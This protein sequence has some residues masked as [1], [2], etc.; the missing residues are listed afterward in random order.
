MN[1]KTEKEALD[2]IYDVAKNVLNLDI[3][4]AKKFLHK[5]A[6]QWLSSSYPKMLFNIS[7]FE[8]EKE[9][10]AFSVENKFVVFVPI[11][12]KSLTKYF[13]FLC[14]DTNIPQELFF[15]LIILKI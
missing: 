4:V 2:I 1:V 8:S 10:K 5:D 12:L 15:I 11:E 6:Y 3:C 7:E 9:I 14:S 13:I